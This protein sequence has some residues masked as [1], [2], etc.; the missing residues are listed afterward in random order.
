MRI[1]MFNETDIISGEHFLTPGSVTWEEP[2]PV[3]LESTRTNIIGHVTDIRREDEKIT[4][5]FKVLE[6]HHPFK[7]ED[8]DVWNW[9]YTNVQRDP[10]NKLKVVGARLREGFA[11]STVAYPANY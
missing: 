11:R 2:I 10:E 3:V 6:E 7:E 1:D 9:Y 5:E 4:G 8:F